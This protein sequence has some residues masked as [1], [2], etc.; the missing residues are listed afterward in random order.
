[1]S[2]GMVTGTPRSW[3]ARLGELL[4]RRYVLIPLVALI[5]VLAAF[6]EVRTS[7]VQA[8]VLSRVAAALTYRVEGGA[9]P[10]IHFP[11]SGPYDERLGYTRL[12]GFVERLEA[13]GYRVEHQA[14][15]SP[16]LDWLAG[17]GVAVPYHEKTHT[18]LEIRDREERRLYATRYPQHVYERFEAVPPLL[19]SALLF[20]EN[21]E[22]L[23][24][25]QP[26]RNP[27]V[28]WRRLVRAVGVDALG[29]LGGDQPAIGASTLPT[30]LEKLRHSPDGRTRTPL[31]KLHQMMT[32]SLRTYQGGAH[33]RA[34]RRQIV[35]DYLD[36]LPLAAA[37]GHG[38]VH[39]LGD[40]LRVWYG[41]D[42]AE[43]NALLAPACS[44]A[45]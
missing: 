13:A 18:G 17:W 25:G 32:A 8:L 41:T 20:I 22:L 45:P 30:Q 35:A 6:V 19:V 9:S 29:R 12:G 4:L 38:E 14:R 15:L 34:A 28:D 36:S 5:A 1:M 23:D 21:R 31:D 37:P 7:V 16:G 43:A 44:S 26:Y 3:S 40:G 39:G 10:A 11:R 42:F 2:E 27:V 33:T 24:P